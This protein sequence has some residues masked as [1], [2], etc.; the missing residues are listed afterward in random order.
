MKKVKRFMKNN[1]GYYQK[2]QRNNMTFFLL[3]VKKGLS[4]ELK[5]DQVQTS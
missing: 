1:P 5:I 3:K 2:K 4:K